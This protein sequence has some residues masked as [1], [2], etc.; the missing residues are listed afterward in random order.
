M[1]F[2]VLLTVPW[3]NQLQ[4]GKVYMGLVMGVGV[5]APCLALLLWV[6]VITASTSWPN[7]ALSSW[8]RWERGGN[9]GGERCE[10]RDQD[11]SST[12]LQVLVTRTTDHHFWDFYHF[13]L[14]PSWDQDFGRN[15]RPKLA[16]CAWLLDAYVHLIK[17]NTFS[18]SNLHCSGDAQKSKVS[19]DRRQS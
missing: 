12:I 8:P 19:W 15:C 6:C 18:V 9:G 14:L 11:Q 4:R 3:D 2:P 7:R 16:F 13:P 5:S 10:R 17:Q 1:G